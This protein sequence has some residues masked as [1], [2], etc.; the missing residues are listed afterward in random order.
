MEN[1]KRKK[2]K[3]KITTIDEFYEKLNKECIKK[4]NID[5]TTLDRIY[6]ALSEKNLTYRSNDI[7]EFIDYIKS[8]ALIRDLEVKL[9]SKLSNIKQITIQ[10]LEYHREL[11][12]AKDVSVITK[13]VDFIKSKTTSSLTQ[14]ESNNLKELENYITSNH[15][16]S[17][18]IELL[19]SFIKHKNNYKESYDYENQIKSIT[20]DILDSYNLDYIK[21]KL[22][23]IEYYNHIKNYIPRIKRLVKHLHKYLIIQDKE[24]YYTL[25]QRAALLDSSNI[26]IVEFDNKFFKA[27]SGSNQIEG[28]CSVVSKESSSFISEK[29]NRLGQLGL[30]YTREFDSEKKILEAIDKG[31]QNKDLT[32]KGE[33]IL[34]SNWEPCPSCY[35]VIKQ[36]NDKYK[37]INIKVKYNKNYGE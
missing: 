1:I 2:E 36:F 7:Y 4:E 28:F 30:G 24:G 17:K 25:N 20:V 8:I 35:Y 10:R 23:S 27:I 32:N 5:K 12:K 33:L 3:L 37:E 26:A 9:Q 21:P 15:L 29:V 19:K 34:Y 11:E 14:K 31:I 18:D 16:F 13:Q 22:G 6:E